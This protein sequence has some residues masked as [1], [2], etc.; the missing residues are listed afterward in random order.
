M[1]ILTS[2]STFTIA[3][4]LL[5]NGLIISALLSVR[6]LFS[7]ELGFPGFFFFF[8]QLIIH[9]FP[10]TLNIIVRDSKSSLNLM[11]NVDILL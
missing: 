4:L 3:V 2:L 1:F 9:Y 8:C 10:D 6:C 7:C 11:E 5:F